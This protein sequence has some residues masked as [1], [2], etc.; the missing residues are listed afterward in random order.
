MKNE[1]KHSYKLIK[2]GGYNPFILKEDGYRIGE[3]SKINFF[4]KGE[5]V[6]YFTKWF[7]AIRKRVNGKDIDV[8]LYP[9]SGN[10]GLKSV[11]L[12][13]DR[14]PMCRKI[15]FDKHKAFVCKSNDNQGTY[16]LFLNIDT[17][18]NFTTTEITG[19][20]YT[21]RELRNETRITFTIEAVPEDW[22]G[23]E[24]AR[25]GNGELTIIFYCNLYFTKTKYGEYCDKLSNLLSCKLLRGTYSDMEVDALIKDGVIDEIA[26]TITEFRKDFPKENLSS[27]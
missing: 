26:K 25:D 27:E 1:E 10:N 22:Y 5:G 6:K 2:E 11:T 13:Y 7:D 8:R 12:P 19:K 15:N 4:K 24:A 14:I 21:S 9:I 23:S 3:I 20:P 16:E 18:N 17:L